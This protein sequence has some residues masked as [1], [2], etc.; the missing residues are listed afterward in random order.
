MNTHEIITLVA[1]ASCASF[2]WG[3]HVEGTMN[4]DEAKGFMA[5]VL[6]AAVIS[7]TIAITIRVVT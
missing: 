2:Y 3:T 4:A 1:I 5:V 7:A 6:G